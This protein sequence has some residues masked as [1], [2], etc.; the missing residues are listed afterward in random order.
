MDNYSADLRLENC[1]APS[2]GDF[3]LISFE[4]GPDI[5]Y[6]LLASYTLYDHGKAIV[7]T[8]KFLLLSWSLQAIIN[9]SLVSYDYHEKGE[10]GLW[11]FETQKLYVLL[12][13]INEFNSIVFL[14]IIFR[15]K[16][17]QIYMDSENSSKEDIERKLDKLQKIR[18]GYII[19]YVIVILNLFVYKHIDQIFR[20]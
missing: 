20:V 9:I 3:Y 14:L 16:I 6:L 7:K 8:N 18:R 12:D 17:L 4:I 5:L 10:P 11:T 19:F 2:L 15:L 13:V 1:V